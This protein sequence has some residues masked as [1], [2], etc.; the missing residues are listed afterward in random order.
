M[1]AADRALVEPPFSSVVYIT[2]IIERKKRPARRRKSAASR[3]SEAGD[4]SPKGEGSARSPSRAQIRHGLRRLEL[5]EVI[6]LRKGG[7]WALQ[8][9]EL[10]DV[11]A[12]ARDLPA[13][14]AIFGTLAHPV[15]WS[16]VA[17]LSK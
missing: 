8:A 14:H 4:G 10:L 16:V 9:S 2:C 5:A 13:G 15:G 11:L 6:E 12:L 17:Q 7:R 3:P 1:G